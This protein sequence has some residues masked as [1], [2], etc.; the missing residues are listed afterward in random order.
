MEQKKEQLT[1]LLEDLDGGV[2]SQKITASLKEVALGVAAHGKVG[3]VTVDFSFKRIGESM[4]VEC[5][6]SIKSVRPKAKG[7]V[8]EEDA[9]STPLHVNGQGALSLFPH[10]QGKLFND[11]GSRRI[12]V[13]E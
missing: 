10:A 13:A 9:T 4:Q 6:H 3:K 2:F 5:L 1:T 12:G 8:I 11:D 7:R